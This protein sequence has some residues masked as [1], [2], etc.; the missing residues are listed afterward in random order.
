MPE[1]LALTSRDPRKLGLLDRAYLDAFTILNDQNE[2]SR[3]F[4]GKDAIAA[5]TQLILQLKPTYLDQSIAIRMGGNITTYQSHRTGFSFRLFDKAEINLASSFY[6]SNG[7]SERQVLSVPG[8]RPN[9]RETRVVMLLHELG[10]L[11]KT[12]NDRWVLPDDGSDPEL[13]LVNTEQVVSVCRQQI[14]SI[15]R[16]THAQELEMTQSAAR[17]LNR[18]D[19]ETRDGK[20]EELSHTNNRSDLTRL[21]CPFAASPRQTLP[22]VRTTKSPF[23]HKPF[24]AGVN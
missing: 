8:F 11:V 14:R 13:S 4:G 1:P 10:H 19:R 16:L 23:G 18:L 20:A 2:C 9:T 6:R 5:L 7:P 12:A 24:P 15:A 22:P 3:F 21:V 17:C